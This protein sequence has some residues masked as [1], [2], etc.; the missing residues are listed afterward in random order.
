MG[1]SWGGRRVLSHEGCRL[2]FCSPPVSAIWWGDLTFKP[3]G[4][5][6]AGD[7]VMG[8]ERYT[9]E[10][11]T[12]SLNR[13]KRAT[14]EAIRV[15][16]SPIVRVTMESGRSFR[17]T[18]DHR[19]YN[20]CWS[21]AANR[22]WPDY[23]Q[24]ITP[25]VGRQLLHVADD[26][27]EV[28]AGLERTAGWLGGIYD[29]EGSWIQISQCPDHNPLV[30]A[31]ISEALNKLDI[32]YTAG[33][34]TNG[35]HFHT[36]T[37]GRQAYLKFLLWCQPVKRQAIAE[38]I[39]SGRRFGHRDR[40]ISVEPDGYGEVLSMTT[41][42]GNYVAWGYASRNCDD[43]I[44]AVAKQRGVWMMALESHVDHR[45]PAWGKGEPDAVYELG[46]SFAEQDKALFETRLRDNT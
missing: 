17:C 4:A 18:P 8:F 43:E 46:Q 19:W 6:Q 34:P 23:P 37:G 42:S 22:R 25:E 11:S 7:E 10:G 40:I 33:G 30:H 27:G 31:A 24:W 9:P 39:A 38:K 13:L 20:P 26:P 36:L 2:W 16:E 14:V 21:P 1:A 29:G 44:V 32:P 45:H 41:S 12:F 35:G 28:P 15:R 3:L 5:V